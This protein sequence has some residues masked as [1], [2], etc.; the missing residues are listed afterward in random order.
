MGG[1][2]KDTKEF[3]T[4]IDPMNGDKFLEVP[5]TSTIEELTEFKNST[6]FSP[7]FNSKAYSNVRFTVC[8]TIS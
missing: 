1:E 2:W 7:A 4:I 6:E 3:E 5:N 8:T